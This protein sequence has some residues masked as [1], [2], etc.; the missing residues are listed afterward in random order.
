MNW[1]PCPCEKL[2]ELN[3]HTQNHGPPPRSA[4]G[5]PLPGSGHGAIQSDAMASLLLP[6]FTWISAEASLHLHPQARELWR[7]RAN[8]AK[9]TQH[10]TSAAGLGHLCGV[11]PWRKGWVV[12]GMSSLSQSV[13]LLSRV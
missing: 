7:T 8:E 1:S 10:K 11:A 9:S 13:Q 6:G 5:E 12:S 3:T 2:E 4:P